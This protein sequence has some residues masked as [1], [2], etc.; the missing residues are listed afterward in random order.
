MY[1]DESENDIAHEHT[2][3]QKTATPAV[4]TATSATTTTDITDN[5]VVAS[6]SRC[7]EATSNGNHDTGTSNVLKKDLRRS[8]SLRISTSIKGALNLTKKAG[9]TSSSHLAKISESLR[10]KFSVGRS[11]PKKSSKHP[12]E[13]I[14]ETQNINSNNNNNNDNNNSYD[15][16]TCS[17][18]SSKVVRLSP[19]NDGKYGFKIREKSFKNYNHRLA[20]KP[21]KERSIIIY[22]VSPDSPA[23]TCDPRLY[24]GDLLLTINGKSTAGLSETQVEDLIK[25]I[26]HQ[27]PPD[28]VLE[29]NSRHNVECLSVGSSGSRSDLMSRLSPISNSSSLKKSNHLVTLADSIK[30]LKKSIDTKELI[31]EFEKLSRKK[32]DE[33]LDESKLM[34]NIEKNRYRDILPYDSTRV[35]LIDSMT[36]DYINA[37]F[38]DMAVPSGNVNRYIATQGPLAST[39]DDFWQMVWEQNCSL[40]IMVTPLVEAGRVKCHK[41]WPD[42]KEEIRYGQILVRNV[43]EKSKTATIERTIQLIDVKVG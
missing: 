10:D 4:A 22:D 15:L 40:I 16:E 19:G 23:A 31:E 43:C 37:S 26:R 25:T 5:E 41:Y 2:R 38:V 9:V 28:L 8:G 24:E 11:R 35:Q 13:C 27:K 32:E 20:T 1:I 14:E 29:V 6:S 21:K 7:L 42:E 17:E 39:C 12:I 36:G 3:N 30:E 18:T 33:S 34:E